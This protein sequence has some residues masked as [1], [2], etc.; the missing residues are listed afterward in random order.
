MNKDQKN[1]LI[2]E[3]AKQLGM[4][5]K[6]LGEAIGYNEGT[7]RVSASSNN[8]SEPLKRAIELYIETVELKKELEAS[9]RFRQN[10]QDFLS[11]AN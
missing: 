6:Q 11:K 1:N 3:T 8:T 9:R 5:Y 7:L 10:L 4:T 2:K